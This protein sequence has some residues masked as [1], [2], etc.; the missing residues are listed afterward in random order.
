M[1][2]CLLVASL[3]ADCSVL[4][5]LDPVCF[6]CTRWPPSPPLPFLP[7]HPQLPALSPPFEPLA[8]PFW[9]CQLPCCVL[10]LFSAEL[11]AEPLL[12]WFTSPLLAP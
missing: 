4:L 7:S 2:V 10:L 1:L 11:F 5:L 6:W 3:S 12:D 9:F 8:V